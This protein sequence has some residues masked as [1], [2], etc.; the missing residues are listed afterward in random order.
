MQTFTTPTNP[1]L[2]KI[3]VKSNNKLLD[4]NTK[5]IYDSLIFASKGLEKID[6]Q[7]VFEET[8]AN[9]YDQI[10]TNQIVDLTIKTAA[11][12]IPDHSQ[13]SYFTGRLMLQ[14]LYKEI[15]EHS[16][17]EQD[18]FY[19]KIYV[20]YFE[21]YLQKGFE[22]DLLD[23]AIKEFDLEK[24]KNAIVPERDLLYKEVGMARL[25]KQYLLKTNNQQ[26]KVFELPQFWL[27]RVAMGLAKLED[28]K[29]QKAIEFY[30]LLS[31]QQVLSATPT[32]LNSGRVRNQCSSCFLTYIKDD[33]ENI[34]KG[35]SDVA[36]LSKYAGGL[37]VD[38][39]SIRSTGSLI[40]GTNGKSLGL[41]P[42]LKVLDSTAA[43]VNQ[44][45]VRKGAVSASIEP[46]HK[47]IR[48][49]LSAKYVSVDENRRCP[50]IHTALWIPDLFMKRLIENQEWTLFSPSDTP[51]LHELYGQEFEKAYTKYE[52]DPSTPK[53]KI[54]AKELWQEI[55]TSLI[56]KGFGHPWI[57]WKDAWNVRS[58]QNHVGVIHS[59]NLC[60]EVGLN[61]S[62]K[63]SAVCNLASINLS[64]FVTQNGQVAWDKLKAAT[65]TA[66]R[67]LD[68]VIDS[69]FYSIP[70]AEYTNKRH[71]PI[72]LGVMGYQDMI[73]QM[74]IAFESQENVDLTDKLFEF[75]SYQAIDTSSDLAK[76]KQS[77][78][79]FK[80]SKWSKG[81][82]PID[83][84]DLYEKE[85]GV[86][87]EVNKK[88]TL[89]WASLRQKIMSQGIRN[90]QVMAIAPTRSISYI[91]GTSPSIEPWDS[92]IFTEVGMTGKYTIINERLVESLEK[93][94]IWNAYLS[95][96]IKNENGSVQNISQIPL[97]IKKLFKTAY[98]IHPKWNIATNAIRQKWIDMSISFNQWLPNTNGKDAWQLYVKCWLA[99]LKSTYYLH[100]RSASEVEKMGSKAISGAVNSPTNNKAPIDT[101][102]RTYDQKDLEG[103][104]LDHKAN[105]FASKVCDMTDP[106]CEACQ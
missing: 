82:L 49:F 20:S 45:G 3:R 61:T 4:L 2:A 105:S 5:K 93:L 35:F 100:S 13:Y 83:T 104:N 98:E 84:L 32:L 77:Y 57:N 73:Q 7:K 69:N 97:S 96:S 53:E 58:P 78:S 38:F 64:K 1:E 56:G 27:M 28:Q 37:G 75:I 15:F 80:G 70:E 41:V 63:E 51:D 8:V 19:S 14:K 9:L 44:G 12:K 48:E 34:F 47:D 22:F 68:N 33:L 86:S 95:N 76:Q 87:V 31:T 71:R 85:R 23:P 21:E 59:T 66:V 6:V 39:A 50:N 74:N 90:S 30:N 60:T 88:T 46:W 55:L 99:G 81:I 92:N 101:Y 18:E 24:I 36:M 11:S 25:Y 16:I 54:W 67:M 43:A 103:T 94:G 72:G 106:D 42:F 89:D 17:Y 91:A 52:K 40:Y 26:Q 62:D 29:E 65:Q 79:T 102:N 10:T